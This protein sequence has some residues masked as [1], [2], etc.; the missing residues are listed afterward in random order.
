MLNYFSHLKWRKMLFCIPRR[1]PHWDCNQDPPHTLRLPPPPPPP[2]HDWCNEDAEQEDCCPGWQ[3]WSWPMTRAGQCCDPGSLLL[4]SHPTLRSI[5]SLLLPAS[6]GE[7]LPRPIEPAALFDQSRLVSV[8]AGQWERS[9]QQSQHHKTSTS[10]IKTLRLLYFFLGGKG[11]RNVFFIIFGGGSQSSLVC[12]LLI[13]TRAFLCLLIKPKLRLSTKQ[14][15]ESTLRPLA[16]GMGMAGSQFNCQGLAD[17]L[18]IVKII[19]L[20][21]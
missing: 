17:S 1:S 12:D 9:S 14:I 2:P 20:N 7:A 10:K 8:R 3:A 5:A 15:I 4:I 18:K 13:I 11:K 6:L 19:F 21:Y 16:L